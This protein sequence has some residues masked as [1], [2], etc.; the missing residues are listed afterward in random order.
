MPKIFETPIYSE[1]MPAADAT[2]LIAADQELI[3]ETW[4]ATGPEIDEIVKR[5]NAYDGL[6]ELLRSVVRTP[7]ADAVFQISCMRDLA[8]AKL[9]E[10][11]EKA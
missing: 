4:S 8:E 1:R 2:L 6:V 5:V 3:L 10:L 9:K 7:S 11:G